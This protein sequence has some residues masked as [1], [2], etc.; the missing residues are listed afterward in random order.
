MG[1]YSEV[2]VAAWESW[3]AEREATILDVREP[4]EWSLGTLPGAVLISQGEIVSRIDEL[5]KDR[6][7]MCVCRSGGRSAN[8]AAFLSFNGFEA[9]NLAG[10]M[11]ALGM[12]D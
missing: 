10:G 4:H 7:V 8:V 1:S 12:Q 11:K 5:P 3:V 2:D 6:P 9:A